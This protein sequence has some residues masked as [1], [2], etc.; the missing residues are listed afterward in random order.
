MK[1]VLFASALSASALCACNSSAPAPAKDA[2]APTASATT[3]AA[4]AAAQA[5]KHFGAAFTLNASEPLSQA[6]TKCDAPDAA[7]KP[8]DSCGAVNG[9]DGGKKVRVRG[10][11]TSVCQK[12]GCWMMLQDGATEARIFTREHGFVLP[13]D[14]AGKT[15]EAEGILQARKLSPGFAKHLAEDAGKEAPKDAKPEAGNSY[16]MSASAVDLID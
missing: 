2:P 3:Q 1:R 15:A 7:Q 4:P 16:V 8:A 10:T 9:D 11:V 13:K 6:I 14:I 12:A 5:P